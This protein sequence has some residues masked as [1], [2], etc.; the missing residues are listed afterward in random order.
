[1][2]VFDR[3]CGAAPDDGFRKMLGAL[4]ASTRGVGPSGWSMPPPRGRVGREPASDAEVLHL[5]EIQMRR[6]PGPA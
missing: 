1:M 5:T 4:T 6:G 2:S 3:N